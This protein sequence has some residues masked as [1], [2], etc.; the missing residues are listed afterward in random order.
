M[1]IKD[2]TEAPEPITVHKELNPKLWQNN[3]LIPEVRAKL[4]IIAKN[5]AD[6]LKVEKLDLRDITISGSN[7]GY[8]YSDS[9]DIDL[10]LV[11]DVRSAER[12]E[13]YDAKKNHYNFTHDIKIYGIDVELYVQDSKQTHFS[14]GIYSILNDQWISEPKQIKS[15]PSHKEIK[16]K[17]RNYASRINQ[18]LR[19]NDLNTAK[20]T[21]AN[22]RRLRQAGLQSGGESSV[23]NLAFKLLRARGQIDKLRKHI[24]RLQSSALSLGEK[25]ES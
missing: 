11:A 18:A 13:L 16:G 21:M 15:Y 25:Y 23:E 5:F 12:A 19:S 8:N 4:L 6:F 24:N 7:A 17:A 2:F 10:H 1:Y 3:K 14:A 20:D 22:I 9:S